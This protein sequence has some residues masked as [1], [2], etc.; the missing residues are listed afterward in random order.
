MN[1]IQGKNILIAGF[2][3][4]GKST[5]SY[6]Q[7]HYPSLNIS[8]A[9]KNPEP[10]IGIKLKTYTGEN[11]LAEIEEFDTI[12]RTPGIPLE[13]FKKAKHVTSHTNI[14]F[15]KCPGTIIAITGTKGKSTTTSLIYELLKTK[16]KDVRLTGNI[17]LPALDALEGANGKSIFVF[18]I[19]SFQLED[20]HYSPQIA[21]VLAITSD[22]V[23]RHGSLAEYIKAK[24]NIVRFQTNKDYVFYYKGDKNASKAAKASSGNQIPVN[25]QNLSFKTKLIGKGNEVNIALAQSVAKHFGVTN[26]NIKKVIMNFKP[27]THRIENVGTFKEI[28]FYDDSIATNPSASING[29]EALITELDTVII[30]GANKGFDFQEYISYVSKLNI[31]NIILMPDTGFEMKKQFEK[32]AK[33]S[34]IFTANTME[35]AVKLAYLHTQ[36]GRSCLLSPAATSFNMFKDYKERGEVFKKCVEDLGK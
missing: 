2:G 14:F 30:G 16:H 21:V 13:L 7:K 5:L 10:L 36:K 29:I 1:E 28:T 20:I 19:S 12:V 35:D 32:L 22:H 25:A 23:D 9:D 27:L 31:K 3:T 4:E 8:I 11:Y 33:S 18:E 15:E 34:N 6:L 17:G 24:Q 26:E